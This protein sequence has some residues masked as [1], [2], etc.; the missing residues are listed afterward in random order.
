MAN[1]LRRPILVL[2]ANHIHSLT[3]TQ[4]AENYMQGIY[5]PLLWTSAECNKSPL[6]IGHHMNHFT[7]LVP[8]EPDPRDNRISAVPLVRADSA[9]L[10]I[11]FM[12]DEEQ[13]K[14]GSLLRQYMDVVSDPILAAKYSFKS[15]PAELDLLQES[16]DLSPSESGALP[17]PRFTRGTIDR[18][19]DQLVAGSMM[20]SAPLEQTGPQEA[21][22]APPR[23]SVPPSGPDHYRPTSAVNQLS[24]PAP[25][26]PT[27]NQLQPLSVPGKPG[28]SN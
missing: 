11:H 9:P 19:A 22:R 7:A 27:D 8:M 4:M 3:G 6:L 26:S 23:Q 2:S 21:Y 1:I 20:P 12:L 15:M 16:L 13:A 24:T 14:Y 17:P 28:F 25:A 10:K 18:S 5:L